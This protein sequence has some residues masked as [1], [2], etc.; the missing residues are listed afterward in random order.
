MT[1][2]D[3]PVNVGNPLT[4]L[5]LSHKITKNHV[6]TIPERAMGVWCGAGPEGWLQMPMRGAAGGPD[7]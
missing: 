1:R 7:R 5:D 6:S 3:D 4:L 2:E